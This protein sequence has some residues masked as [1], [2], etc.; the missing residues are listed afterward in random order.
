MTKTKTSKNSNPT[1][2]ISKKPLNNIESSIKQSKISYDK[3]KDNLTIW[4][5]ISKIEN[6]KITKTQK[7]KENSH[8]LLNLSS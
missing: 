4:L 6:N 7:E 2:T 5:L 3:D 1:S 8:T